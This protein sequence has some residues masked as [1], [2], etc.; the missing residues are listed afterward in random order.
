MGRTAAC[1]DA[2]ARGLG[3]RQ[4]PRHA[5]DSMAGGNTE[6]AYPTREYVRTAVRP[7]TSRKTSGAVRP[8]SASTLILVAEDDLDMREMVAWALRRRGHDVIEC[9]NGASLLDAVDDLTSDGARIDLI[10][11]DIRMPGLTGLQTFEWIR[12]SDVWVPLIL[13][14][15]FPDIGVRVEASLLGAAGFFVKPFDIEQLCQ[16]ADQLLQPSLGA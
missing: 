1:G 11:S 4:A 3:E 14:T 2:S 9:Q 7:G 16:L 5:G 8:G 6:W 12:A 10:I 15:A 13:M